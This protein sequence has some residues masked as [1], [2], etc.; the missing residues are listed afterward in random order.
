MLS[1]LLKYELKATGRIF[2]P[3]FLALLMFAGITRLIY[4]IGP[5][6]WDAPASISMAIYIIIMVGMFVMT[7]IM[8][9]QRFYKNLLSDEGYLMLTLPVKPWKH[10]LSKL[11]V[12]MLWMVTSGIAALISILIITLEKGDITKIV[13]GLLTVYDQVYEQLGASMYLLSVEIIIGVLISLASGILILYASIALGHLFSKHRMLASFGAFI[14]LS[15]LSQILFTLIGLIPEAYFPDI[16]ISSNDFIGMQHLIQWVIAG[17]IIFTGLLSAA[18]FAI[19]NFILSKRL[20][21]E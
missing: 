15:T 21:L 4:S 12:S 8:M 5:E 10:I 20:N 11:L 14:A 3:L 17:G 19:T 9:I 7:F 18:Y 6:K 16:H 1:K 2:L 13:V